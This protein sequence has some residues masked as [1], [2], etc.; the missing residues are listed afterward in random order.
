[1][2]PRIDFFNQ[3]IFIHQV[4]FKMSVTITRVIIARL[5]RFE[6]CWG[7]PDPISF[8]PGHWQIANSFAKAHYSIDLF[9]DNNEK[10]KQNGKQE[11]LNCNFIP[12]V[13]L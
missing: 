10:E 13:H 9:R 12:I 1:M 11:F 2:Y 8:V 7:L 4:E 6:A 5:T 3:Q